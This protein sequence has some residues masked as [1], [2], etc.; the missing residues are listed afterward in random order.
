MSRLKLQVIDEKPKHITGRTNIKVIGAGGGGCNALNQMIKSHIEG[1]EFIAINTDMQALSSCLAP[2]RIPLGQNLTSGLGAGGNPDVGSRAA[3][4]DRAELE[5]LI[6]GSHMVFLTTG[7]GGGTGTGSL[8]ILAEIAKKSGALV[9]AIVTLPF[10]FEGARK[11]DVAKEGLENLRKHTD[12]LIVIP[13]EKLLE[14][15][16][17]KNTMLDAF[18]EANNL[19]YTG[20]QGI[21]DLIN[22]TGHINV[23]FNDVKSVMNFQGEA[24]MGQGIGRGDNR[25]IDALRAALTCPLVENNDIE[26]AKGLLVNITAGADFSMVEYAEVTNELSRLVDRNAVSKYGLVFDE[27]L[28]DEVKITLIA[29]G[30]NRSNKVK[31]MMNHPLHQAYNG[32]H[33]TGRDFPSEKN[34]AE[35][36]ALREEMHPF[37]NLPEN[38]IKNDYDNFIKGT[39]SLS[40]SRSGIIGSDAWDRLTGGAAH[41]SNDEMRQEFDETIPSYLRMKN[42]GG[43]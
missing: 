24:I 5:K 23:D 14:I 10:N 40:I 39:E 34:R 33:Q 9:V 27:E 35:S 3:Q 28:R 22:H 31:S 30:F 1:V 8:P 16:D 37:I 6:Q 21:V 36:S 11:L 41:H 25:A 2:I 32:G 26:G 18:A 38:N 15:S 20:V 4:E 29:T 42:K 43:A 12:A 17:R 13:N 19:L 7:L